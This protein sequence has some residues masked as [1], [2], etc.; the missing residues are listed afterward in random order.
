MEDNI[1]LAYQDKTE[2]NKKLE[3]DLII[4][5]FKIRLGERFISYLEDFGLINETSLQN[6]KQAILPN[7]VNSMDASHLILILNKISQPLNP[8]SPVISIH[9]CF[10]TLPNNMIDLV[11]K[12]FIL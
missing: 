12:E 4:T 9:D 10:G 2:L 6:Q 8:I 5:T 7:I 1:L 3:I 11:K